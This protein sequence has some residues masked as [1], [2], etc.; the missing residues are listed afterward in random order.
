MYSVTWHQES[1]W[2]EAKTPGSA[3]H[4]FFSILRRRA[5]EAGLPPSYW[6][7]KPATTNEGGWE[8]VEV[9]YVS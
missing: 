2:V 3:V 7:Q 8:G 1:A 6:P 9:K 4:K 5:I